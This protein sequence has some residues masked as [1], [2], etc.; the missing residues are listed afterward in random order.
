MKGKTLMSS[1]LLVQTSIDSEEGAQKI[2]DTVVSKRLGACCWIYGPISSTYWWKN[3]IEQNRE[4]VC[5]I[6]TRDEVYDDLEQAIKEIHPYEEPEIVAI[7]ISVG[8]QSFLHWIAS[9]TSEK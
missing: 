2:A 5:Q 7:P 3:K 4:W 6:K 8:S 1:F 9:E